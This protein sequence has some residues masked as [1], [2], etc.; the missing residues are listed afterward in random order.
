MTR[1][2]SYF[3]NEHRRENLSIDFKS[4]E[5]FDQETIKEYR[6]LQKLKALQLMKKLNTKFNA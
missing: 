5:R 2:Q 1:V 6:N 4:I 3:E